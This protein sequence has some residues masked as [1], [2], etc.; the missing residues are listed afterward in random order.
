MK[1]LKQQNEGLKLTVFEFKEKLKSLEDKTESCD[2]EVQKDDEEFKIAQTSLVNAHEKI[3]ALTHSNEEL[4]KK[5]N[6]LEQDM[7]NQET[8]SQ[9]HQLKVKL[10]I[11]DFLICI[12]LKRKYENQVIELKKQLQEMKA[13]TEISGGFE[14]WF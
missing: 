11:Q 9:N 6:K 1:Q 8:V 10:N 7:D 13:Q 12:Q 2:V 5:I 4:K 3:E 14:R